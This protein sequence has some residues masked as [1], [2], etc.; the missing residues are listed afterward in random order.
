VLIAFANETAS[1][2]RRDDLFRTDSAAKS[3]LACCAAAT[4]RGRCRGAAHLRR[5]AGLPML[6]PGQLGVSIG[7]VSRPAQE[8]D[9]SRLLSMADHALYAPSSRGAAGCCNTPG[10]EV[11]FGGAARPCTGLR[12]Q[13]A[14]HRPAG[15][16]LREGQH[17]LSA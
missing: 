6:E 8:C 14:P 13:P 5:V 12:W 9:L 2:L 17:G 7:I 15:A 11:S 1:H 10:R 3:S 16:G 4:P